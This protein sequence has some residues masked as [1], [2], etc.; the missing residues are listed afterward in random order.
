MPRILERAQG[1]KASNQREGARI[2]V[3]VFWKPLSMHFFLCVFKG[4]G[5][6]CHCVGLKKQG[7][8]SKK[9]SRNLRSFYNY[10]ISRIS[11]MFKPGEV[12]NRNILSMN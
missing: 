11:R 6:D 8:N 2:A 12:R 4:E 5:K 3:L 9:H 7:E 10:E 1:S